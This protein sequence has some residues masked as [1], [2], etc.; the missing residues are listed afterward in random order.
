LLVEVGLTSE[1]L[2]NN[3]LEMLSWLD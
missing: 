1:N 3:I 2:K